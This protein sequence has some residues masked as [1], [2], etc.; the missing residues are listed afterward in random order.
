MQEKRR[1]VSYLCVYQEECVLFKMMKPGYC[2][3]VFAKMHKNTTFGHSK[4]FH[5][6][7]TLA[8]QLKCQFLENQ[9]NM[10]DLQLC[11]I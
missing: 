11:G 8:G 9:L 1:F 2:S 7:P 6:M 3:L 10:K 4:G 5:Y